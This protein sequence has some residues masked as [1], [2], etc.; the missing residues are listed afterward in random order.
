[1]SSGVGNTASHIKNYIYCV[2]LKSNRTFF[3]I[4]VLLKV[5]DGAVTIGD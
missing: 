5:K 2:Y 1:M 3:K 4:I